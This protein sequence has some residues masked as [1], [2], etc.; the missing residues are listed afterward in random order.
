MC[1]RDSQWGTGWHLSQQAAN[2]PGQRWVTAGT[3]DD[4][5]V[6]VNLLGR[7]S[8]QAT[9]ADSDLDVFSTCLLYTSRCV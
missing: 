4:V 2:D 7:V 9:N 3:D 5:P 6:L 8:R 1:I